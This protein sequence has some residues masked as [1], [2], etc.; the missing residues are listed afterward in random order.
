MEK[1]LV[2]IKMSPMILLEFGDFET[3]SFV[4]QQAFNCDEMKARL[5]FLFCGNSIGDCNLNPLLNYHSETRGLKKYKVQK[6]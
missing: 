5:T 1:G 4:P 2:Q 3:G 6:T